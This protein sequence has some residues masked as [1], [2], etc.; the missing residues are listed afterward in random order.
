MERGAIIYVIDDDDAVR[1]SLRALLEC[2]GFTAVDF[3]SCAAFLRHAPLQSRDC[4][5]LDLHMPGMGGLELLERLRRDGII[6]AAI[7]MTGRPDPAIAQAA[8]RAGAPLL[9]KPFRVGD[10]LRAIATVHRAAAERI[11]PGAAR[12]R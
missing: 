10:L 3:A 2:E 5:V 11:E 7:L 4:L 8:A 12:P 6:T 1:D 9:E